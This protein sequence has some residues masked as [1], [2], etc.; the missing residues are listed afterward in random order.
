MY[1]FVG[2]HIP[3][4]P[5]FHTGCRAGGREQTDGWAGGRP[6]SPLKANRAITRKRTNQFCIEKIAH[7]T[8]WKRKATLPKP[9]GII[10][11]CKLAACGHLGHDG[12]SFWIMLFIYLKIYI[13]IYIYINVNGTYI[14]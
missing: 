7:R 2:V 6:V 12:L 5:D 3:G 14:P 1:E 13:Y 8:I 11:L 9:I 4:F 10:F